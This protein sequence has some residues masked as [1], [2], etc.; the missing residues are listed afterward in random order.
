MYIVECTA[1]HLE[2]DNEQ[3]TMTLASTVYN[4]DGKRKDN[5]LIETS[6]ETKT[7]K[8][9]QRNQQKRQQQSH[10]RQQRQQQRH[11]RQ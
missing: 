4:I 10:Q 1:L 8:T 6:N 9:S 2:P 11:Q 7:T 5:Y 3:M